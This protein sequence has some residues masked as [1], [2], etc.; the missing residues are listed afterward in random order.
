[1]TTITYEGPVVEGPASVLAKLDKMRK[2]QSFHVSPMS[3]GNVMVQSDKS[4][5]TFD[6]HTGVG[7]LNTKGCYFPHLSSFL[8]AKPFAFPADFVEAALVACPAM[9]SQTVLGG[10]CVIVENTV[11]V[12][13]SVPRPADTSPVV[14]GLPSEEA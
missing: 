2:P 10:G 14:I 9:G 3:D 4:I 13:K 12:L 7:V 5:G 6:P 8:G 1:M 11:E